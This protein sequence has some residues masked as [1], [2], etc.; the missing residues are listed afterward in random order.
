MSDTLLDRKLRGAF[1]TPPEIC[2]YIAE[3]A[4]RSGDDRV[5]EPSC[6]E[7]GFLIEAGKQ[8]RSCGA[9]DLFLNGQLHGV[10]IHRSSARS[11]EIALR[12]QGCEP[13]IRVGNFFDSKPAPSF[14][15][16]IGNPPYIRYQQHSGTSRAKSLEAAL[17]EGVRLN[18]LASSWAAFTV[19]STRFLKPGGR[20]GLVLPAELLSVNYAAPV[21]RFLL[22]RFS[23]VRLVMFESLVFPGALEEVVLLL[24]EGSGGA[25][26]FEVYQAR[27]LA[28]LPLARTADWKEHRPEQGAK[29]T[30]AL[31]TP[32]L[33]DSYKNLSDSE[34]F[35]TLSDWGETYLGAVTGNND[36][37][38]LSKSEVSTLGLSEDEL[39]PISPPGSRHLRGHRFTSAAWV[40]MATEDAKCM[41]FYPKERPSAAAKRYIAE[42]ENNAVHEAYKCSVRS[43]WWQVP[44][45][46]TP[47]IFLTYMNHD[48]PRLVAN[49]SNVSILNS[50][51]GVVLKHGRKGLGK[52]LLPIACLN[53]L[54]LLGAEIVGRAYGG[55]L[56][57]LEPREA[58]RLPVPSKDLLQ[59]CADDLKALAPQLAPALRQGNL[60]AAVAMVDKIILSDFMRIS[61]A[62]L[63]ELREA[64]EAFFSRRRA[65]GKSNR[66]EG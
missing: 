62:N 37:F 32:A 51:Y 1:F 17:A 58:D 60:S 3:W 14:D 27:D 64:R 36:F 28:A 10:E 57:K 8:L 52:E 19:H 56:L 66:G 18:G 13:T 49:D 9:T 20:L 5:L 30:S 6:G 41:L 29:W 35:E 59:N 23:R 21:R 43:P 53:S 33:F 45:V 26:C 55:G 38:S 65:R 48:R 47:D 34:D 44:L 22:Q 11:S 2:K 4:V 46:Q 40:R 25:D 15:A 61:A 16:V 63:A 7:A 42:G 24:A 54:T 12:E 39:V 50:L 31:L